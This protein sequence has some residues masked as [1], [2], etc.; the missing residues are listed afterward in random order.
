MSETIQDFR[1]RMRA[2]RTGRTPEEQDRLECVRVRELARRAEKQQKF[3]QS[4]G[5]TEESLNEAIAKMRGTYG[6]V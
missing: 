2:L 4:Y 5:L 3:G 6:V 1:A